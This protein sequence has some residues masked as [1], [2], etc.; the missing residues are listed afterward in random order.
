MNKIFTLIL[1]ILV[2]NFSFSQE[3]NTDE[4]NFK[5]FKVFL[6][7]ENEFSN[8]REN[9]NG[10]I[11]LKLNYGGSNG[12]IFNV[13]DFQDDWLKINHIVGVDGYDISNFEAWIHVSIV[14]ASAT[15]NLTLMN[16]AN[17]KTIVGEVIGEQDSFKITALEC[18]WIE[19]ET[20]E[21]LIGWVQSDKICGNPV[22][23]CP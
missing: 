22:T 5:A 8:I 10:T 17:G 6:D 16:Q 23:T 20:K 9:P 2:G 11:I 12:Y 1:F 18:D 7:D 19:I 14:G 4:C 13:V 21:G 15:Y 3:N